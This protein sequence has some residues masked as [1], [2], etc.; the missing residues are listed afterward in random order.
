VDWIVTVSPAL[1]GPLAAWLRAA[2]GSA[3]V[4]PEALAVAR[5]LTAARD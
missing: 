1:A 2:A 5:V 3:T 4:P